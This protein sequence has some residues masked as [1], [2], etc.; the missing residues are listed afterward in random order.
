MHKYIIQYDIFEGASMTKIHELLIVNLKRAREREGLS[1]MK[2]AHEAD[3]SLGFI[4]DI[5]SGKRFPS[6]SSIEKLVTALD[7]EPYELFLDPL[8]VSQPFPRRNMHNIKND[9][10]ETM[11]KTILSVFERHYV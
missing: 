10:L 6:P 4:G 11:E 7:I 5:E 3:L 8:K 2:L 9:L 1:Q